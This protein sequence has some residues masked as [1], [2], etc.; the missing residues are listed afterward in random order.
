MADNTAQGGADV[1]ATDEVAT[2]NG[3]A[4]SGVK[5]Q[6]VKIGH[7][8]DGVHRDASP[9][10]PLP[11]DVRPATLAVTVAGAAAAAATLTLPAPAAGMFHYIT[12]LELTLYSTAARTGAAA[13]ITVTSTNL[14]GA[15]AFTFPT[16]GVIGSLVTQQLPMAAPLRSSVAATA[17]TIVAPVVTGGLWRLTAHYYTA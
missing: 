16:A 10:F 13:P 11:V 1:I 4:S 17:T 14:P 12:A 7:G 3:A 9:S 8:D 6:R 15:L 2:L 5:V